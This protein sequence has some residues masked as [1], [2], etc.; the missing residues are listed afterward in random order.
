MPIFFFFPTPSL[1]FFEHTHTCST[2]PSLP[3]LPASLPP[4]AYLPATSYLFAEKGEKD[5]QERRRRRQAA[6]ELGGTGEVGD[7]WR[8]TATVVTCVIT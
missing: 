3:C 1:Y 6:W 7:G 4:H 8:T 5:R 2:T